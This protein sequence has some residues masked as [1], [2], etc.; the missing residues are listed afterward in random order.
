MQIAN[1]YTAIRWNCVTVYTAAME[2]G[3]VGLGF[4]FIAIWQN[5][6]LVTGKVIHT[7]IC[8]NSPQ[9]VMLNLLL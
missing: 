5:R 9:I 8:A 4:F 2:R 7:L 1:S 6:T 3:V